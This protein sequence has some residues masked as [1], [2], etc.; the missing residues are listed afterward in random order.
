MRDCPPGS[1][2]SF[3]PGPTETVAGWVPALASLGRD[4]SQF[5]IQT[6][7]KLHDVTSGSRRKRLYEHP[8]EWT[9]NLMS[10]GQVSYRRR[11]CGPR[12]NVRS[13]GRNDSFLRRVAKHVY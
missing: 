11:L 6:E 13:S 10:V 9:R 5:L 1:R 2:V 8:Q 12:D 3:Y 7:R 4:D